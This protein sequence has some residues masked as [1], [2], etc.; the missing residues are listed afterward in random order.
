MPRLQLEFTSS[1]LLKGAVYERRPHIIAKYGPPFPLV[2]KMSALAQT[3]ILLLS[4][5]IYIINFEKSQI[6]ALKSAD[7]RI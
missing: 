2:R 1:K 5:W 4:E 3:P 6:F 7:V